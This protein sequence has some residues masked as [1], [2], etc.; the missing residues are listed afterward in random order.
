LFPDLRERAPALFQIAPDPAHQ[1]DVGVG[2]DVQL[3]LE[4]GPEP[5]F[6]Q[7]DDALDDDDRRGLGEDALLQPS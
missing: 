1:P 2:V 7:D 3:H 6:R 5:I 4:P